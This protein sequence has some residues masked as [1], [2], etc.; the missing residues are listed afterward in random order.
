MST[1]VGVVGN[2]SYEGL[3]AILRG[4]QNAE[5]RKAIPILMGSR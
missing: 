4:S 5:R 2:L 3:P 1:R